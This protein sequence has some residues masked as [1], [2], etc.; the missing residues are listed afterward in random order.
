MDDM[1]T[2]HFEPDGQTFSAWYRAQEWCRQN[3]YSFG[4]LSRD[5]PVAVMRGPYDLPQKWKNMTEKE[6]RFVDGKITS[7]DFREGP[8]TITLRDQ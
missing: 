3:G 7:P 6:R 5:M 8:V 4:S 1:K 2:I